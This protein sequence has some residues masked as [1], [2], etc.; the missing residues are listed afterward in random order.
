MSVVLSAAAEADLEQIGDWIARD[1]PLR[2]ASFVFELRQCCNGLAEHPLRFQLVGRFASRGI[3]RRVHGAYLIFY[4]PDD[5]GVT[6]LRVLHGARDF[7]PLLF[8]EEDR[9]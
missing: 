5:A 6:V 9:S 3:R 2:A 4:R 8:P 1:N 7:E